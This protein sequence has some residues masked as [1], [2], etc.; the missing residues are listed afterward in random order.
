MS[1]DAGE[2]EIREGDFTTR[3]A[4]LTGN[5]NAAWA[6]RIATVHPQKHVSLEIRISEQYGDAT[7]AVQNCA[8]CASRGELS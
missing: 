6:S 7:V 2:A 1:V 3:T 4:P 5:A 8:S